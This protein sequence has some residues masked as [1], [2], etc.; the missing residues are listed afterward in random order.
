MPAIMTNLGMNDPKTKA[1]M[2]GAN[3]EAFNPIMSGRSFRPPLRMIHLFSVSKRS[4]LIRHPL[5]QKLTLAGCEN[6]ER[7]VPCASFGDPIPQAC[8]DQE[9]GGTRIDDNDGWMAAIDM[10]NPGNFTMDPYHGSANPTFWAN[11]NGTNLIAEGVFPSLNEVPTEEEIKRAELSR[12]NH[13]RY[14]TK[15]AFRLYAIG[16]KQGNEF[17]QRFPDT[18]IAM[19]ALGMQ[20]SWHQTNTVSATCPN[21]GD[22]IKQGIAFHQS[23]A[24]IL[25]VIEPEKALKAGAISRERYTEMTG[26]GFPG[27]PKSE[28]ASAE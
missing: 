7:Y 24:G 10:L 22:S 21:C 17:I 20:A 14:L 28:Q 18:H 9:R 3:Q 27:R 1:A 4:Y 25:C 8:P 26:K 11:T 6:G 2:R 19:D 15:E 13:Y 5:F 16:A 23:S 12:D